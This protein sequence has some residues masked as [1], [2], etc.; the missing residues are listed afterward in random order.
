MQP[1][2]ALAAML[3]V[4]D[5]LERL[6]VPYYVGGSVASSA[7]GQFRA[8]A[9][10]DVIADLELRHVAGLVQSLRRITTLMPA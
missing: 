4:I 6:G 5:A 3:P 8:T 1:G 9:D 2:D 10:A 7:H